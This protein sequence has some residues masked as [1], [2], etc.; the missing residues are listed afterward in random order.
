MTES[1]VL[2]PDIIPDFDVLEWK[3]E[4]QEQF[5]QD[6]KYMTAEERLEYIRRGSEKFRAEQRLRQAMKNQ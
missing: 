4:I 2:S 1:E 3:R 5:Y 6:T